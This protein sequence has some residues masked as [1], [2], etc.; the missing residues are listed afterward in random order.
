MFNLNGFRTMFENQERH[1]FRTSVNYLILALSWNECN[2]ML[3]IIHWLLYNDYLLLTLTILTKP[4]EQNSE[5][6]AGGVL[7]IFSNFTGK[8]LCWSLFFTKFQAFRHATLLKR[9][10]Y[11]GVFLWNL[12]NS[13][14]HLFRR[15]F[16]RLLLYIDYFIIF[17]FLQFTTEVRN[18]RVTKST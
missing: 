8:H 11:T 9:D 1:I 17:W 16:E 14:E 4:S 15:T 5:A 10:S 12:R 6:A 18:S 3:L 13:K 7:K 2:I